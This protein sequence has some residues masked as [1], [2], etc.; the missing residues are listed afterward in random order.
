MSAPSLVLGTAG[1]I[2]HGKSS[3]VKAL[4]GTDPDRLPEEKERGVTIELGFAQL[5]L[6]SGRSMGV[7]DVPGHERFVRQMVAGATGIDVV[8]FVVA[9]DDGVMPQTREHLA[10]IDLL[11]IPAG[12][13]ALTKA[14]LVDEEWLALVAEDVR[15]LISG[16]SIAGAPIVP[17][18]SKTGQGLD[19]LL[20]AIDEVASEAASRH[21]DLPMRLPVDRVFTIAG[22]G[23]VVTGTLWSGTAERDAQ[24][25]V[26]PSG[27]RGRIRS[28]QVHGNSV[29]KARAGNR[30]ALN[31]AGLERDEVERGDVVAEPG[32]LA[33]TDRFDAY[34]TYLASE[35]KP[36]ETGTRVHVHHGTREVLGRVLLMDAEALAP[37]ESGY[38]QVRL[39]E[40]LMPRYGDRFIVRRYSPMWTIGGG[41][42]LD[43]LPPRRTRLKEHE[44]ALL[45]AL[46]AGD[47]GSAAVGLLRSR[48]VPMT[49]GQV[50]MALGLPRPQVAD[51]LNRAA[52]ERVK[53]GAETYFV[54]AEALA[55]LVEA[56]ERELMAFHDEN[57][58]ATGISAL[59]LRDR[60]DRRL[61]PKVFDAL[62]ERAVAAGKA[63]VAGGEVR[64]PRAASAALA[65]EEAVRVRLLALLAAQGLQPEGMSELAAAAGAPLDVVRRVLTKLVASGDVVRVGPDLH[66]HAAAV[67][68]ARER[69]VAYL[70]EHGTMLAKDARDVT[71]SSRK[72]V[73]PLLEYFDVQGVTKRQGDERVLGPRA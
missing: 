23:T 3:L 39:E 13:V 51:Q 33:V 68:E 67:S 53:V 62:V 7:V 31:L 69:I 72:Y 16:T 49:S 26:Y 30:V 24:V 11:G 18:S 57:P 20:A 44:R 5:T 63:A 58:T 42:I 15:E 43:V 14:D 28:V 59:A 73:V 34:V 32:S 65:E 19:D 22:A 9:A 41:V 54:T 52:L 6:P 61:D 2:D 10:I 38:A 4:T 66:F 55:D 21:A 60:V 56:V 1:H 25:E 12:V 37:G 36:F 17:V 50:A 35:D 70:R 48:A 46:R 27:R 47:L 45:D 64:H 71:G 29:E 8:L 40:P